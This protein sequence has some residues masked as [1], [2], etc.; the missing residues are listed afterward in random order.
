LIIAVVIVFALVLIMRY[1]RVY[2][3]VLPELVYTLLHI[4][5]FVSVIIYS[6]VIY[7]NV[8][9]REKINFDRL[10]IPGPIIEDVGVLSARDN[11][12]KLSGNLLGIS[13]SDLCKG[14]AC[15]TKGVTRWDEQTRRCISDAP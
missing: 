8:S 12:A 14:A 2:F 4:L 6:G 10:S 13:D 3:N 5:L 9:S 15:C 7:V 1:M 11:A